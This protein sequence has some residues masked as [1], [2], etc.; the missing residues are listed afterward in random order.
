[1][2]DAIP[3]IDAR[4]CHPVMEAGPGLMSCGRRRVA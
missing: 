3:E 2:R 1:M 4:G